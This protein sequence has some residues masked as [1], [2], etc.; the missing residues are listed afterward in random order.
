MGALLSMI[1]ESWPPAPTWTV[2]DIPDL[3]GKV[4][5]VTGGNTG[6]GK[7]TVRGLL[8]HNAKV[9]LAARDQ[10]KAEEAIAE[11]TLAT[12]NAP[13][14]LK[15]DLADLRSVKAAAD[16][17]LSKETEL[18]ILIN[19][20]GVMVPPLEMFTAQGSYDLQFGTN[21]LG[22]F[23]FTKLL[24]PTLE[25]TAQTSSEKHTRVVTVS[26]LVHRRGSL[27]FATFV[28][29]PRRKRLTRSQLYAQSKFGDLVFATELAR[30]YGSKGVVSISLNPGN[31]RSD[32]QR[33]LTSAQS[34]IISWI[35]YPLSFGILNNLYAA[36]APEAE[37][38]NGKFLVPWTRVGEPKSESQDPALG[39]ELWQWLEEQVSRYE[40]HE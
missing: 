2:K 4:A 23:Y 24:L 13:I 35:L 10:T 26:S 30:R 37:H 9:Y 32:L 22:H 20:A 12:N 29:G 14:F 28:D 36:T 6:I 27:D 33:H 19:N 25:A 7:G 31:I 15:L 11:L 21:V 40:A 3:T 34:R 1:N 18:H 39:K 38:L 16:E 17:F 8:A 5:I